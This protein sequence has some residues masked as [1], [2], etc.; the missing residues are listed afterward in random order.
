MTGLAR[1]VPLVIVIAG[2]PATAEPVGWRLEESLA[3]SPA[4]SRDE[5]SSTGISLALTVDWRD[6]A[7]WYLGGSWGGTWV[8]VEAPSSGVLTSIDPA[9]LLLLAGHRLG[10]STRELGV[11]LRLG[12]PL[13]LFWGESIPDKR[14]AEHNHIAASAARAGRDPW[15]WQMNVIPVGLDLSLDLALAPWLRLRLELEPGALISLNSRPSRLAM[16]GE[17]ELS[18]SWRALSSH[19]GWGVFA[20]ASPLENGDHDQHSAWLGL[21]LDLGDGHEVGLDVN[22]NLDG[23]LGVAANAPKPTWGLVLSARHHL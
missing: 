17:V 7:G 8:R 21:A 23:P 22:L 18:A 4:P 11:G 10:P 19:L 9:N 15:L 5:V 6:T 13:A 2:G 1:V 3:L 14:A 20:S 16:R 12:V